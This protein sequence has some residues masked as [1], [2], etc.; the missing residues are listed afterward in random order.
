MLDITAGV[1]QGSGIGPVSY[2][3]NAGDLKPLSS[4]NYLFKYAD[5]TYLI[6]PSVNADTRTAELQVLRTGPAPTI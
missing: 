6:T 4:D 2:I 1:I 5:A 3:I